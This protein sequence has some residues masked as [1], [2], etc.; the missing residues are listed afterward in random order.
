[1]QRYHFCRRQFEGEAFGVRKLVC[2]WRLAIP[3][4]DFAGALA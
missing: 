2:A 1:M 3:G 4:G